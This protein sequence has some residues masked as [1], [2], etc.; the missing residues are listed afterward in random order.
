MDRFRFRLGRASQLAIVAVVMSALVL[1]SAAFAGQKKKKDAQQ[2][3]EQQAPPQ[4]QDVSKLVWPTPPNIPRVRYTTYFAGM[5]LD[6]TPASE[7]PKKKAGW[8]D[9]LAGVQ[10]PN[11]KNHSKPVPFQLISPYGM[12]VN[13]KGDLYVADQ[14][15]GAVFV[16]NTETK[17]VSLIGNG[18]DATF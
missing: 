18:R 17:D 13:S 14:R 9:R 11:N 2:S 1:P 10:D 5:K 7:Q 6:F 4:P 12:A 3:T 15:V 8:M 16:F